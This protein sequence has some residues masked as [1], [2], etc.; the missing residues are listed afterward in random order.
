MAH[1]KL[2]NLANLSTSSPEHCAVMIARTSPGTAGIVSIVPRE[3]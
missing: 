2:I 1:G 3:Y